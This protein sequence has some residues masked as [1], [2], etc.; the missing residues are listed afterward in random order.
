[1]ENPSTWTPLHRELQAAYYPL[2]RAESILDVLHKHNYDVTLD[3][4]QNIINRYQELTQLRM[5]GASLIHNIIMQLA[6]PINQR[7]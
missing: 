6:V 5:C 4:I 1:M 2:Q 3:Q 7:W